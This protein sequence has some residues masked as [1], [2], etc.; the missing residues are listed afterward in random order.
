M[1]RP[2]LDEAPTADEL[3]AMRPVD[4]YVA[5]SRLARTCGTLPKVLAD[6]RKIALVEALSQPDVTATTLAA[7]AEQSLGRIS[8]LFKLTKPA[9]TET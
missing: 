4:R 5:L 8:Q 9:G 3:A 7:R 2:T 1:A 6:A